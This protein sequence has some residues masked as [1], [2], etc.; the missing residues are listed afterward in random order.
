MAAGWTRCCCSVSWEKGAVRCRTVRYP[1][2][3]AGERG[4]A[5][6]RLFQPFPCLI[7]YFLAVFLANAPFAHRKNIST[8]SEGRHR[9]VPNGVTTIGRLIQGSDAEA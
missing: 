5:P 1:D 6:F 4:I 2:A 9:R 8:T 3:E 7:Y